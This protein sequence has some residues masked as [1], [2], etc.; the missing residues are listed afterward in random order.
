MNTEKKRVMSELHNEL[1]KGLEKK[2]RVDSFT[3][4]IVNTIEDVYYHWIPDHDITNEDREMF[5]SLN[6]K[7]SRDFIIEDDNPINRHLKDSCILSA[8]GIL[9]QANKFISKVYVYYF[10]L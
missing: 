4:F 1:D 6:N 5:K 7:T 3:L 2:I 8:D 9:E 10:F